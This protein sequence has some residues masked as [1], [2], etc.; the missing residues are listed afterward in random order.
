MLPWAFVPRW[1][2]KTCVPGLTQDKDMVALSWGATNMTIRDT[3]TCKNGRKE[4]R[5]SS[6]YPKHPVQQPCGLEPAMGQKAAPMK[7]NLQT[8]HTA[9]ATP[10]KGGGGV[11]VQTRGV[12]AQHIYTQLVRTIQGAG[13]ISRGGGGWGGGLC[14]GDIT[15]AVPGSPRWVRGGL[16]VAAKMHHPGPRGPFRVGRLYRHTVLRALQ[17][18]FVLLRELRWRCQN[19]IYLSVP[20]VCDCS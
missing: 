2:Q 14:L 6:S 5:S 17:W 3:P 1:P 19:L 10:S 12:W 13:G 16:K 15:P 18:R 8:L 4:V 9:R 20:E 11:L 7:T